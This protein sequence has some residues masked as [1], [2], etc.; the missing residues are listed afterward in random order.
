[1]DIT[2]IVEG[3]VEQA[4]KQTAT[5]QGHLKEKNVVQSP[6]RLL[7]LQ[8]ELFQYHNILNCTSSI[9]KNFKD[10]VSSVIAKI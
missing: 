5:I 3:L 4:Q 6:E 8:F 2:A 9:L 10:L 1:M 7:S